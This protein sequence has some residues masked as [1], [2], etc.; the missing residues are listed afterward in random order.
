MARPLRIEYEGAFYHVTA[1]GNERKPVFFASSDY[2]RFKEYLKEAQDKHHCL[3]HAYVLMTNHYHL[4]IETPEGNLGRVMHFINA[5]YTNHFNRKHQRSGHLFQGRYK[6]ILVDK[7]NYLLQLSL[8]LHLNP[9][10][11]GVVSRPE[12]YPYSSYSSFIAGKEDNLVS[13]D[14]IWG[15]ISPDPK[16]APKQYR[17]FVESVMDEEVENPLKSTFGG[18]ILGGQRFV[19]EAL[20]RLK[21]ETLEDKDIS[22]G[23]E[24]RRVS[25]MGDVIAA[26]CTRFHLG[27]EVFLENPGDLRDITIFLLKK[28]TGMTNRQISQLPGFPNYSAV[29]KAYQRFSA[30]LKREDSLCETIEIIGSDLSNV[31][32]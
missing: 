16:D 4:L 6:A 2:R 26:V 18:V 8:Y 28:H 22:H 25:G 31:K 30:R 24:L 3:L 27:R 9:V 21:E 5:S 11:A 29:A 20:A 17:R 23:S 15:M 7:D 13:R 10:R 1:R 14:L 32:T 19:K 12:A